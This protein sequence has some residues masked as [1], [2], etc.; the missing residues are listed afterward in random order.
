MSD[1]VGNPK[2]RFSHDEVPISG[3]GA[4]MLVIAPLFEAARKYYGNSGFFIALAAINANIIVCGMLCFPS[5][6]EIYTQRKRRQE[7]KQQTTKKQQSTVYSVFKFYLHVAIKRPVIC[8]CFCLFNYGFGTALVF[9]HLPNFAVHKGFTS[10]QGSLLISICGVMG[11]IGRILTGIMAN[12]EKVDEIVL[13]A[14]SMLVVS[15]ATFLFP[16]YS[17]I[18]AGQV[19]YVCFLGMFFGSS[20]VLTASVNIRFAGVKCMSAA[21]GLQFFWFGIGAVIGPVVAGRCLK[22]HYNNMPV[23]YTAN[24]DG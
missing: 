19:V 24:F 1:L 8:L 9:L 7:I 22:T 16:F 17:H 4:G 15:I 2:D 10:I 18:F 3:V 23:Q 21:T 14:G 12:F 5:K 6:L 13:Y 20:Y 11:L